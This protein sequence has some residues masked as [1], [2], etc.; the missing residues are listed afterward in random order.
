[1][2]MG[3]QAVLVHGELR[4]TKDID[5]TLGVGLE[6]VGELLELVRDGG[7][8]PLHPRPEEFARE[9]YVL[10]C[11]APETGLRL[12]FIFSFSP[13][14]REA[15]ARAKPVD[16]GGVIVRFASPEDLVIQKVVA[17]RSRDLEDVRTVL[18]KNPD[19]DLDHVRRWLRQFEETLNEPFVKRLQ[20]ILD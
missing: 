20:D 10:P 3:G 6:A 15:I 11:I 16:I 13:Y 17:G 8:K 5:I 19:M 1:M 9:T 14:E 12:D 18:L 7:W 4:Q 2:I